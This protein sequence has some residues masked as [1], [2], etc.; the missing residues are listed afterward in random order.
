MSGLPDREELREALLGAAKMICAEQP[1]VPEPK[2]ARDLDSFS[3]VQVVLEIE[4]H[5]DVKLLESLDDFR[6]ESFDD[7]AEFAIARAGAAD[8]VGS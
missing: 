6:G 1:D 3:F 2:T 5:Y 7:L 4:N 8:A